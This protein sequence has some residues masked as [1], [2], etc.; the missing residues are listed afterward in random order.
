MSVYCLGP[1]VDY[2]GPDHPKHVR[3]LHHKTG[4]EVLQPL[5]DQGTLLYP[6]LEAYL[7]D[8]PRLGTPIVVT[9]GSRGPSRPYAMVYAQAGTPGAC[10]CGLRH[11]CD[12]GRVPAWRDD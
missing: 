1:I 11:A 8:L 4:E 5:E 2:R 7:Q 10:D 6:E 3:I 12:A 9:K